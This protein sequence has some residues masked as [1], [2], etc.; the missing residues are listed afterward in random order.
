MRKTDV[1]AAARAIS[2]GARGWLASVAVL[3][4]SVAPAVAADRDPLEIPLRQYAYLLGIALLGGLV[5]WYSKVQA[6]AMRAWSLTAL[7]GELATSAFAGLLAF[8]LC[9]WSGTPQLVTAA[10]VGIAGH[11]GTRAIAA[12]EQWAQ[13]RFGKGAPPLPPT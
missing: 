8:W 5:S 4:D 9:A 12:F 11:M 13:E 1:L 6:G 10:L 7:I 3:L 2:R